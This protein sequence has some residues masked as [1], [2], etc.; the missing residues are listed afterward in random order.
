[1][2]KEKEKIKAQL[3]KSLEVYK[4][5]LGFHFFDLPDS[6][7]QSSEFVLDDNDVEVLLMDLGNSNWILLTTKCLF[8]NQDNT[9]NR[10]DG[11]EIEKFKF[12]NQE[13]GRRRRK[14]LELKNH[15]EYKR[16]LYSGDFKIIKKDNTNVVVNLPHHDFGFSMYKIIDK[17]RFVTDKYEGI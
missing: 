15:G 12:L 17:L 2:K 8:I 14:A 9:I 7:F 10:V 1:M 3:I 13:Q 6:S 11:L 4:K 16:W 5:K